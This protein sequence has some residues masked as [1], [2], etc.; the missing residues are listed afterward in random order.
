MAKPAGIECLEKNPFG[1]RVADEIGGLA[2][3]RRSI[4][5]ARNA[6]KMA[7]RATSM[8][9]PTNWRTAVWT[10]STAPPASIMTQRLPS[11]SAMSM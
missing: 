10:A 6:V 11:R 9:S 2:R 5:A 8:R 1:F 3:R 7:H 4:F